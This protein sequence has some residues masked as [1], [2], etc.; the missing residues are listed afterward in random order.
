MTLPPDRRS[1]GF[2]LVEVMIV[3]AILALGAAVA[4]PY[5]ARR[6]PA[7]ALA[8]AAQEVRVALAT[9][10]S[11][12]IAEDRI[13]TFSGGSGGFRIDGVPHPLAPASAIAIETWGRAFISFFPSGASSGGRVIV[14]A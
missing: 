14:H 11:A 3:L 10:R 12:A 8:A 7:A 13:V 2:T 5:L 1:A 9:A 4:L 6:A